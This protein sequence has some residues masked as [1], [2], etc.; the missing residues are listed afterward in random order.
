[1]CLDMRGNILFKERDCIQICIYTYIYFLHAS[2]DYQST[3][4]SN[5]I[6]IVLLKYVLLQEYVNKHTSYD[7]YFDHFFSLYKIQFIIY[8]DD[9]QT[10]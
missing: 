6:C 8:K 5:C 1:M 10:S 9:V 3:N 7:I 4:E 2:V